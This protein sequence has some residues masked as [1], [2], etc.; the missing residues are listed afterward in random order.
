MVPSREIEGGCRGGSDLPFLLW[1]LAAW[2]HELC[3]DVKLYSLNVCTFLYYAPVKHFLKPK[4]PDD[5][6]EV[7]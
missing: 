6:G 1:V 5:V 3:A 4:Q 2:M 7:P